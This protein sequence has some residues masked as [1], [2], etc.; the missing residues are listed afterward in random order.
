L[1]DADGNLETAL[2]ALAQRGSQSGTPVL[3]SAH[4]DAPV[5]VE[6]KVRNHLYR[7]AQE[8]VQ[9]SLRH[10][11][12]SAIHIQLFSSEAI[13]RLAVLDD[14]CGLQPENTHGPGLGMRTMR[15]R[16]SAI[17]GKLQVGR[18]EGGGNSVVCDVPQNRKWPQEE[19]L[20]ASRR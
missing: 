13:L 2:E 17:G 7:I 20:S 6:L 1:T 4:Y 15:F 5:G 11:G 8:A 18:R 16:A 9:N 14:G 3:F 10:S 12:A 19:R